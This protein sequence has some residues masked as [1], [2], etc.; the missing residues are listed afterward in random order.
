[1]TFYPYSDELCKIA[2]RKVFL[3]NDLI[4][5]PDFNFE[6]QFCRGALRIC[7]NTRDTATALFGCEAAYGCVHGAESFPSPRRL[8]YG[9]ILLT[10]YVIMCI[11][12]K[13]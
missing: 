6:S 4:Q 11:F 13:R 10:I 2:A 1:M 9:S 7:D 8:M 5:V 12:L 3:S